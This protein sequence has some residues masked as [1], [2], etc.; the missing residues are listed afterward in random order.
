[1]L[2]PVPPDSVGASFT[3]VTTR[4]VMLSVAGPSLLLRSKTLIS[5]LGT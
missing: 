2:A 5:I 4:L 3:G 1:M